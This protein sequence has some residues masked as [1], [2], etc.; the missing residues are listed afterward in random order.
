MSNDKKT[1]LTHPAEAKTESQIALNGKP[2]NRQFHNGRNIG[3]A[4]QIRPRPISSQANE[5]EE[6]QTQEN[7]KPP[8]THTHTEIGFC[9]GFSEESKK[10]MEKTYTHTHFLS[11]AGRKCLVL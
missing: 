5:C 8:H 2:I 4:D 7:K 9:G 3:C 10:S 11:L 6:S 1:N